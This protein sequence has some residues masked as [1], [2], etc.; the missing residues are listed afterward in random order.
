MFICI[1][2]DLSMS[3]V[4]IGRK[5]RYGE[6]AFVLYRRLNELASGIISQ[7]SVGG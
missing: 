7:E 6:S 1:H 2:V 3:S 5:A 4:Y